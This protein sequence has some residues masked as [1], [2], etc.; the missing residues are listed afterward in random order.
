M[1]NNPRGHVSQQQRIQNRQNN[2]ADDLGSRAERLEEKIP[3]A[4]S[5]ELPGR[6]FKKSARVIGLIRAM[7]R[8]P[9]KTHKERRPD[10]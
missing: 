8:T 9:N 2:A 7:D 10:G 6:N 3:W 5:N 1:G 4:K